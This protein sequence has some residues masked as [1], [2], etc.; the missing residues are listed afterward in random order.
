MLCAESLL[1]QIREDLVKDHCHVAGKY[2]GAAR[3][4]CNFKL[5]L[6]AEA[7]PIPVVFHNLKSH[8]GQVLMQA[9]SRVRGEIK[10]IPNGTE[11]YVSFSLGDLRFINT[12]NFL[13]SSLDSLAKGSDPKSVKIRERVQRVRV[14][15]FNNIQDWIL[16]SERIRKRVMR[17]FSKEINPRSFGSWYVKG[18][19]K[20]ALR[21]DSSVS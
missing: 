21:V 9:M 19:E 12:M 15:V 14:R 1:L 3:N 10:C 13:M 16:K 11:K 2:L 7:V 20:S 8:D 5:R 18:T 17:F 4:E 6:N